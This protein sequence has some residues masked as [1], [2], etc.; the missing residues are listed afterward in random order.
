M[1]KIALVLAF[2]ITTLPL[3]VLAADVD[4]IHIRGHEMQGTI[5]HFDYDYLYYHVEDIQHY[6]RWRSGYSIR[7]AEYEKWLVA[8]IGFLMHRYNAW[9]VYVKD[10]YT[11]ATDR[12]TAMWI[13][14]AP[15][16]IDIT[17]DLE[18]Y[19]THNVGQAK[20]LAIQSGPNIYV[21]NSIY[22][23]EW[24]FHLR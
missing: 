20:F 17:G 12:E 21:L 2:I 23:N 19:L 18:Y 14:H 16:D 11:E 22:L 8:N 24:I 4:F 6:M 15:K 7:Q 9:Y 5:L 1:R 13:K 10:P 3:S